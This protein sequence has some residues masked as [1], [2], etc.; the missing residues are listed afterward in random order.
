M[1]RMQERSAGSRTALLSPQPPNM[2]RQGGIQTRAPAH[3]AALVSHTACVCR[4]ATWFRE[5]GVLLQTGRP[6]MQ[7][8]KTVSQQTGI[9]RPP[10]SIRSLPS[11]AF[12]VG[13]A[14]LGSPRAGDL[15]SMCP[16]SIQADAGS[17]RLAG[18]PSVGGPRGG[19]PL[20]R[21]LEMGV[22]APMT[23]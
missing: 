16:P 5:L 12:L 2:M 23:G 10:L 14:H 7:L 18:S 19:M 21:R 6:A 13:K 3:P 22:Q 9:R 17:P 11:C 20:R 8:Q 1:G 4:D 15:T